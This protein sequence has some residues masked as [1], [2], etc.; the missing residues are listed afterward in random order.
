MRAGRDERGKA[1][2]KGETQGNERAMLA[3]NSKNEKCA[4]KEEEEQEKGIW[5]ERE[6]G[7]AHIGGLHLKSRLHRFEGFHHH[8]RL[9]MAGGDRMHKKKTKDTPEDG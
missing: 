2:R 4:D 3:G 5:S 8:V 1:R 9:C 6:G 7:R